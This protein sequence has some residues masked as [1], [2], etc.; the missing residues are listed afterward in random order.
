MY[1]SD[2]TKHIMAIKRAKK[3]LEIRRKESRTKLNAL[4]RVSE[5]VTRDER[6]S[7]NIDLRRTQL[8]GLHN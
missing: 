2:K 8:K 3:I 4:F 6:P 1:I 5:L 7:R